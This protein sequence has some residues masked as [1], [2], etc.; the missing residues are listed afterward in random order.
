MGGGG[1]GQGQVLRARVPGPLPSSLWKLD[2]CTTVLPQI[3]KL[4]QSTYERYA[5][6]SHTCLTAGRGGGGPQERPP[7]LGHVWGA[8]PRCC[9]LRSW[10]ASDHK[11][12]LPLAPAL[13]RFVSVSHALCVFDSIHPS[14]LAATSRRA[15][16]P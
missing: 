10:K 11:S 5:W 3:E 7:G 15:A 6:G 14:A 2:L 9:P 13:P 4:L 1:R 16:P 12:M 8:A